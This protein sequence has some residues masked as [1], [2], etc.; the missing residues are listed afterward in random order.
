LIN[1]ILWRIAMRI[2]CIKIGGYMFGILGALFVWTPA[3]RYG[4]FCDFQHHWLVS[5]GFAV[6]AITVDF[7][8]VGAAQEEGKN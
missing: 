7:V 6:F 4:I 2:N 1:F 5:A 8:V 3:V